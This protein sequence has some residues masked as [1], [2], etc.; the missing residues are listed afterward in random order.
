MVIVGGACF[1]GAMSRAL[2]PFVAMS[3]TVATLLAACGGSDSSSSNPDF[4]D[5]LPD[6]VTDELDLS[7]DLDELEAQEQA[8]QEA[9]D[10]VDLAEGFQ[11]PT[12]SNQKVADLAPTPIARVA[13][14]RTVC[15]FYFGTSEID[16]LIIDTYDAEIFTDTSPESAAILQA[17][18][19]GRSVD[20]PN[21]LA[22]FIYEDGF[23]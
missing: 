7:V 18:T 8:D 23:S 1:D 14:E 3:V 21:A 22:A 15:K 4:G 20:V 9:L 16:P 11:C 10:N 13:R 6:E 2:R 19:G 17:S 12:I 5:S